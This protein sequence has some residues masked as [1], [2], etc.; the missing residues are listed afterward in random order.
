MTFSRSSIRT[1]FSAPLLLGLVASFLAACGGPATPEGPRPN[2]V[3]V[4]VDT[5]RADRLGL[6][7]HDL[8]T[9]PRID[10]L[11]SSGVVFEQASSA[12]PWTL[13]SVVSL[14]TS[15]FIAEH[16]VV[17]DGQVIGD[18]LMTLA[19]GLAD[20]GYTTAS[21]LKNPY[22]GEL[23]G[24]H[25]GFDLVEPRRGLGQTTGDRIRKWLR[26]APP[27]PHFIYVHNSQP[28][29]PL[30]SR[31]HY[32]NKFGKI[33][34]DDRED[35]L[36]QVKMYRALTRTDFVKK[37]E[38]GTT[39][40]SDK[41]DRVMKQLRK[42]EEPIQRAYSGSVLDADQR[43]GE[44]ID[45]LREEGLWDNTLFMVMSDHG[46]EMND[47]G[48]W[49]H[50]QS[51][52]QELIHVPLVVRF[53]N[54]EYAGLRL[55]DPVSLVDVL[56][57]IL[58]YIGRDDLITDATGKS[59]LPLV[60]EGGGDGSEIRVVAMRH[61]KKKYYRPYKEERGDLNLVVR[62]GDWKAILNLEL[63]S[64]E[65]YDLA[66]DPNEKKETS[67]EHPELVAELKAFGLAE[68]KRFGERAVASTGGG[69][70][71]A[72]ADTLEALEALG[73]IG[74]ED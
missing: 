67:A 11:A 59:L 16:N 3:V 31:R 2:I 66:T 28:H 14:F 65:L 24:L 25:R 70:D 33:E 64:V 72:D 51:V 63:D 44:I 71:G 69:L 22:G 48:G 30:S 47:H 18:S 42:L 5:L 60:A 56:P 21:F 61:N 7:G 15:R 6:Y 9:S 73:Y 55:N 58:D 41:Q 52:Y 34:D 37:R 57:T 35:I 4:L 43:I 62:K 40:N 23:S 29:D 39:D 46:E 68:L 38:L 19:E 74:D 20:S 53:P 1:P 50:D 8:E 17:L 54:D 12:A 26:D 27:G 49:Q 13:P 10:E 45:V 32:V 36:Q